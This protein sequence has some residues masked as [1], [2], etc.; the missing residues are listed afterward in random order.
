MLIKEYTIDPDLFEDPKLIKAFIRDFGH[1][2]GRLL[3]LAPKDW[4]R[5]ALEKANKAS[6]S[7]SNLKK[8]SEILISTIQ[9]WKMQKIAVRSPA[10]K[11]TPYHSPW[12]EF[13]NS[14]EVNPL[15]GILTKEKGSLS[16]DPDEIWLEPD[17]W[18]VENS[19][20][21]YITVNDYWPL[22]IRLF[23]LS[24]EVYIIDPYFNLEDSRY[25]PIWE[26]FSELTKH[27]N[28]LKKIVFITA[29]HKAP[30]QILGRDTRRLD[31]V[32]GAEIWSVAP[33]RIEGG[34]HDR[35][36]MT[37][38]TGFGF[39]NSFQEKPEQKMIIT[40][41]GTQSFCN[42]KNNFLVHAFKAGNRLL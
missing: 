32:N 38:L 28:H 1:D 26:A 29:D 36:I 11:N 34:M 35:F 23:S 39:S 5:M 24:E 18:K 31:M 10:R 40:R 20:T 30:Q 27:F 17:S 6:E 21:V 12:I 37:E 33:D 4:T 41:L 14:F 15:D 9:K 16:I 8:E 3:S 7:N 13:V 25:W 42:Q 2:K 22:L 19:H